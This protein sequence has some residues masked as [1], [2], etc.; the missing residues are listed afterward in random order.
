MRSSIVRMASPTVAV[1]GSV[2]AGRGFSTADAVL[3]Q[4][5]LD[6][7]VGRRPVELR[8]VL[9]AVAALLGAGQ[10]VVG[11]DGTDHVGK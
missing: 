1:G 4:A 6:A 7:V 11:T 9:Q 5:A 10:V 2:T 8:Q 3:Q